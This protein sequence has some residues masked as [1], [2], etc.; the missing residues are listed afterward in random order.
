MSNVTLTGDYSTDVKALLDLLRDGSES[1][2]V[3]CQLLESSESVVDRHHAKQNLERWTPIWRDLD[4]NRGRDVRPAA[5]EP[6]AWR[7]LA[8]DGTPLTDWIDGAPRPG[9]EPAQGGETIQVAW[10]APSAAAPVAAGEPV[11]M[12]AR[13]PGC[14]WENYHKDDRA[15]LVASGMEIRW[16]FAAPPAAA[17]GDE[18]VRKDAERYQW[19]CEQFGV[20]KL[21]CAL[22]RILGGEVYVADGKPSLDSVIDAAMRAQGEGD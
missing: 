10:S 15:E 17:H 21:P 22:E 4:R 13:M 18:A 2:V 11:A 14:R 12:Q 5:G 9:T 8:D 20:T 3:S 19:L 7:E 16:L 1:L 6:V